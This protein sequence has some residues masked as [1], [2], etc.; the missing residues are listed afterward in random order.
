MEATSSSQSGSFYNNEI[1][2]DNKKSFMQPLTL[3]QD[4]Q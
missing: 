2:P 1:E 3:P 4:T